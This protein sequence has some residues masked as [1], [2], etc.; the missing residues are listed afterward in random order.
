MKHR[1]ITCV[2]GDRG[3]EMNRN[4]LG[5]E[6]TKFREK[7]VS[8]SVLMEEEQE[9]GQAGEVTGAENF[10]RDAQVGELQDHPR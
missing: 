8:T 9:S 2:V 3:T 1:M 6:K 10:P 5:Q 7:Q 4:I